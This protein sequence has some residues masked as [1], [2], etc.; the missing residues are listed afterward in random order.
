[1]STLALASLAHQELAVPD[2]ARG[3]ALNLVRDGLAALLAGMR[4]PTVGVLAAHVRELECAARSPVY[5]WGFA[6]AP[7]EAAFILGSAAHA[8][9]FEPMCL[10]PTHAVSPVLGSLLALAHAYPGD[11]D[12]R[13]WLGA[14]A[15]G[16]QLQVDLRRASVTSDRKAAAAGRHF[17]FQRQGFHPPGTVG[18][19]GSALAASL[20]LESSVEE[21]ATALGIA[22]SRAG[23]IAGNIGT[24]TKATHCGHAA[25]IGVESALLARRGLTASRSTLEGPAGWGEVFGGDGFDA[26]AMLEGMG[27]LTA[28]IEPSFAFKRWP[29]H[30]AMQVA[31]AAGLEAH[32]PGE[33]VGSVT[34]HAPQLR[35]CDRPWPRDGDDARFS[36]QFNAA[37]AL[38]DGR[39]DGATHSPATLARADVQALLA[40]TRL[41]LDPTIPDTFDRMSVEVRVDDGRVGHADRWPGHWNMPASEAQHLDKFI[42]CAVQLVAAAQAR[43]LEGLVQR[44][45]APRGLS[46][47]LAALACIDP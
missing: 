41:V 46:R 43:E 37:L 20:W 5:G 28:V 15:K 31:I 32:R 23:G 21:T 29:A 47:L 42:E 35:Y 1:M 2:R 22:A 10:P 3:P 44:L 14:F 8:L 18:P 7:Q 45:E 17:P 25:R 27:S 13:R 16:L 11:G 6:T 4:H 30:T 26:T 39:I 9:D 19:L 36:F 12:G 40:R 33:P 24:M 34:I 38:L